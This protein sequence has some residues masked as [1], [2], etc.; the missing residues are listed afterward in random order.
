MKKDKIA[1]FASDFLEQK[2]FTYTTISKKLIKL[3]KKQ[4]KC[5]FYSTSRGCYLCESMFQTEEFVFKQLILYEKKLFINDD[6]I[7]SQYLWLIPIIDGYCKRNKIE[8][9]ILLKNF[10]KTY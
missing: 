5:H 1:G 4:K 10:L 9:I 6:F 8:N 3:A 7:S 2:N